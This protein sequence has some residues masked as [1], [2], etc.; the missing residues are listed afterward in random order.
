LNVRLYIWQ[1]AT[2]L[3]LLPMILVHVAIIF[4]AT[5]NG[6]TA[7]EILERTRGSMGW[8]LYYGSFVVA[9]S[10]HGAIGVRNILVEWSPFSA[11]LAT[12]GSA[13]IGA[14]LLLLGFRA[15]AAVVL[16]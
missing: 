1:R 4:Q 7:A 2:A 9:A 12:A 3:I 15:V 6:V 13:L 11:R 14:A 8:A 10:I 16:T 5:R